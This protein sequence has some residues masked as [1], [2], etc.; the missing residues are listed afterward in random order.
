MTATSVSFNSVKVKSPGIHTVVLGPWPVFRTLLPA[1]GFTPLGLGM[2]VVLVLIE[3]TA[4]GVYF[5][6]HGQDIFDARDF[7]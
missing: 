7:E 4:I 2:E 3:V 6:G 5:V 1:F